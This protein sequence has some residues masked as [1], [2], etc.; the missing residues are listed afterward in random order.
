[1]GKFSG[2]KYVP[3]CGASIISRWHLLSAAH[4]FCNAPQG[5]GFTGLVDCLDKGRGQ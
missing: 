3:V 4:C 2:S 5:E 1:M